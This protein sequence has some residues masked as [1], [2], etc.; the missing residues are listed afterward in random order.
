MARTLSYIENWRN[1]NAF[2]VGI[3]LAVLSFST[4]I[5]LALGTKKDLSLISLKC[6]KGYDSLLVLKRVFL[7]LFIRFSMQKSFLV[8]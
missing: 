7:W 6:M 8:F 5:Y 1:C 2:L 3:T 4:A